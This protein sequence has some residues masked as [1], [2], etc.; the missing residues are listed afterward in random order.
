MA[1]TDIKR[2]EWQANRFASCLLLPK[3]PVMR[4]VAALA[5]KLDLKNK[6]HGLI[7]VDDQRVN[8]N[9]FYQVTSELKQ[10]YNVSRTVVRNRLKDLGVLKDARD[11]GM[12]RLGDV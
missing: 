4:D 9:T 3:G 5:V 11:G 7:Y 8:I 12:R 6:G 10:R 1:R 2:M